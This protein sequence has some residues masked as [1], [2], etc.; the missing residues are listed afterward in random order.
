MITVPL[1]A[2]FGHAPVIDQLRQAIRQGRVPQ[3]LILAG[4]DGVGKRTT[5]VALA[6]ALNCPQRSDGDG[7]GLCGVCTRIARGEFYDVVFVDKGEKSSIGIDVLR[8]RV[9]EPVGYRPFEGARRV[10]IIDGADEMTVQAQDSLLKTL[11][12][13]PPSA[14]L[15]LVT[16]YP[17]TLLSTIRSRCRRL[18]FGPLSE[19]DVARV[20]VAHAGKGE[21]EAR[22]RAAASGGSVSRALAIEEGE[23][24]EDREAALG[25][26]TAAARTGGLTE[27]LKAAATFAKHAQKRRARDAAAARL[28]IL[29][30]L[31][32][33]LGALGAGGESLLANADM[34]DQLRRL[35]AAYPLPRVIDAV[36]AVDQAEAA[37]GR[38]ASAKIVADWL[39]VSL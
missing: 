24:E 31:L 1:H 19:A 11:E 30:S 32:R 5:A 9:L 16:A 33:D 8:D 13:P 25:V 21:T 4:P 15:I 2:I 36:A 20:L 14:I 27:R 23:F 29:A 10:F 35:A 18:R 3:S 37:L 12:E 34:D 26:L 6:Q 39:A 22:T 28:V 7:C 38:N 17:D